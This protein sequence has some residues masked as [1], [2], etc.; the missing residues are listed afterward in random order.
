MRKTCAT[1]A[2]PPPRVTSRT[3]LLQRSQEFKVLAE[4]SRPAS[5]F[6][7]SG[8]RLTL[9]RGLASLDAAYSYNGATNL[10]PALV[11]DGGLEHACKYEQTPLEGGTGV[12]T[13][14]VS[15]A[16]SRSFHHGNRG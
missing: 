14:S 2:E 7:R 3:S 1:E 9:G 4:D 10:S 12:S 15:R 13:A 5:A 8:A 6:T 16:L 11:G